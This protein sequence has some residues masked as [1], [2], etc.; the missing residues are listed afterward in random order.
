MA[1]KLDS[2]HARIAKLKEDGKLTAEAEALLEELMVD[3]AEMERSNRALRKAA[4]KAAGG[5]T[6]SSRLRDALYE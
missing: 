3:L 5:Q 2:Y 6:M 1:E 4:V